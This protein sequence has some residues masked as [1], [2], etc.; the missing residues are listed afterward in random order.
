MNRDTW[1]DD[2]CCPP[3]GSISN[4]VM[5]GNALVDIAEGKRWIGTFQPQSVLGERYLQND[6]IHLVGAGE[7]RQQAFVGSAYHRISRRYA[8]FFQHGTGVIGKSFTIA[9]SGAAD[10][11]CCDRLQSSDT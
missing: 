11:G 6:V 7:I 5:S 1:A 2:V 10:I 3:A 9:K 4:A 8:Y